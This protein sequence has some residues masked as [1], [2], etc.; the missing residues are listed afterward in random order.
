MNLLSVFTV[1][2]HVRSSYHI[3]ICIIACSDTISKH[4][5]HASF[6]IF[7]H[8]LYRYTQESPTLPPN[9]DVEAAHCLDVTAFTG[10]IAI[11]RD[12]GFPLSLK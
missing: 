4:F 9:D 12:V 2:N 3:F 10:P 6:F 11:Y 5:G 1:N 8:G 7:P